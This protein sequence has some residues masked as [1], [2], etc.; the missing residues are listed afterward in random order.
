MK[1]KALIAMG[2]A[3][4]QGDLAKKD[5]EVTRTA[6]EIMQKEVTREETIDK[7]KKGEFKTLE[8]LN[9][10]VERKYRW[11]MDLS[12]SGLIEEPNDIMLVGIGV[13]LMMGIFVLLM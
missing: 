8:N 6:S 7:M 3:L 4:E 11:N 1:E 5:A 13:L 12:I 10:S 2:R 9:T